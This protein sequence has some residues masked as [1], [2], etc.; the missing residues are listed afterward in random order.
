MDRELRIVAAEYLSQI[1]RVVP[2]GNYIRKEARWLVRDILDGDWFDAMQDALSLS[3][4]SCIGEMDDV[5][6]ITRKFLG[7]AGRA[8]RRSRYGCNS[9]RRTISV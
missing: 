5:R 7:E 6:S 4:F 2:P 3:A 8:Y 9:D 1:R